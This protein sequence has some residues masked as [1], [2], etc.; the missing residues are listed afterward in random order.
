M[1]GPALMLGGIGLFA[2]LD[3]NSK[4]LA[5]HYP[6]G[7]VLFC[8]FATILLAI[9]ALRALRPGVG[10][11]LGGTAHPWLHL[12]RAVAMLGSAA[13]FFLAFR[14]LPLAEGY[15]VFFTAPFMTLGLAAAVLRER[16]P[17]AAWAWSGVGFLGVAV[18]LAPGLSGAGGE[19]ALAGYLFAFLGTLCY[20]AVFTVNRRLRGERGLARLLVWPSLLGLAVTAPFAAAEWVAPGPVAAIQLM[21]NGGLVAAATLALAAAFRHADAARLAPMEF[22]GLLWS[23]GFDLLVWHRPPTAASLAGGAIVVLA[24]LMSERAQRRDRP[25]G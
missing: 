14:L 12:L 16:M 15:L 22:S 9:A 19:R 20:S 4:L 10:G 18:A 25:E 5:A 11:P 6:A 23:V 2:L 17:P 24:C 21:L 7:Q 8:R 13:F 3:A 1:L